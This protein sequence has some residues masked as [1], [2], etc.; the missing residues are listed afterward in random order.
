MKA[1]YALARYFGMVVQMYV[2][3]LLLYSHV[4]DPIYVQLQS[5]PRIR[6]TTSIIHPRTR[7]QTV[8][9]LPHRFYVDLDGHSRFLTDAP[10]FNALHDHI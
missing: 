3:V 6:P 9:P 1:A 2:K 5:I 7:L 10:R 8:V 4:H